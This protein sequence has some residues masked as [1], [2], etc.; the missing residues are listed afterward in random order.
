MYKVA[1]QGDETT[2]EWQ[3]Q[4]VPWNLADSWSSSKN[5]LTDQWSFTHKENIRFS[6]FQL[7]LYFSSSISP[8]NTRTSKLSQHWESFITALND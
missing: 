1:L 2:S 3:S 4:T 8:K 5:I 6:L 7:R